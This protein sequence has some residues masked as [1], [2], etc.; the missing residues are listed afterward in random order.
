MIAATRSRS[1]LGVVAALAVALAGCSFFPGAVEHLEAEPDTR[2]WWCDSTGG[3]GHEHGPHGFTAPGAEA[4]KGM[5]AW[6][7]C[8]LVSA[9]FD[10]VSA[11]LRH[12]TSEGLAEDEG[13]HQVVPYAAGMGTH[14]ADF[15]GLP[16]NW[17]DSPQF[18]RNDPTFPGT[19]HDEVFDPTRPEYLMFDGNRRN[20]RLTGMAWWVKTTDGHP[21]EGFPGDN[22]V[23]HQHPHTCIHRTAFT[24]LG[25][26]RSDADCAASGGI[27][28]DLSHWWMLHAWILPEW[29][30]RKDV[31]QNHH[32]C[33]TG[34]G[35]IRDRDHPC[36]HE[37][38]GH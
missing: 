19:T 20:A 32:P 11:Y 4:V 16:P 2:P 22:D 23:W 13:W 24:Y 5:L 31:F 21:P 1:R 12:F 38:M 29:E 25:E 18:D 7:D 30:V 36:W 27:N 3:G 28:L 10:L 15:S 34:S 26:N 9:Q 17:L 6:D 35:P 37:A 14:H 8:L 33:L